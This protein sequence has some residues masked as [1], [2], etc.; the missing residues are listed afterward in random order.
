MNA[1]A[2]QIGSTKPTRKKSVHP[3]RG[4]V[5]KDEIFTTNHRRRIAWFSGLEQLH[6]VV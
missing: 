1:A 6:F 5:L 2:L 3:L 4:K